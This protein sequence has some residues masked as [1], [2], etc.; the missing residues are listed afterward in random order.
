VSA[1]FAPRTQAGVPV[2]LAGDFIPDDD[3]HGCGKGQRGY[4]CTRPRG[5]AGRHLA[6]I[7]NNQVVAAW[8]G[9][10]APTG[11]DLTDTLAQAT[12]GGDQP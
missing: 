8:P 5:H 1:W 12:R 11:T 9:D 7:G 2:V 3:F 6:D 4:Y 10:H